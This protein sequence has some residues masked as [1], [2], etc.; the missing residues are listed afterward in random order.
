MNPSTKPNI[1]VLIK[2]SP[3]VS[4]DIL[5]GFGSLC[6]QAVGVLTTEHDGFRIRPRPAR[7]FLTWRLRVDSHENGNFQETMTFS[8]R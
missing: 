1:H 8:T 4:G 5:L 7:G 6:S 2:P 3:D